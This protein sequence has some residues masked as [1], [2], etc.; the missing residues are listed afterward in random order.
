MVA[1]PAAPTDR[2]L[3][4]RPAGQPLLRRL[5]LGLLAAAL[6]AAVC[7]SGVAQQPWRA[8]KLTAGELG[9]GHRAPGAR[10]LP[11]TDKSDANGYAE[12]GDEAEGDDTDAELAASAPAPAPALLPAAAA[13]AAASEMHLIPEP[14]VSAQTSS[15]M[16]LQNRADL[17]AEAQHQA[18]AALRES[19]QALSVI[20]A[21]AAAL[22]TSLRATEAVRTPAELIL[23]P[24]AGP[25]GADAGGSG[26]GLNGESK[27]GTVTD[28]EAGEY[29]Q[30]KMWLKAAIKK[31]E[32]LKLTDRGLTK[33]KTMKAQLEGLEVAH[34]GLAGGGGGVEELPTQPKAGG[35]NMYTFSAVPVP[36]S[37]SA[38]P[39]PIYQPF[40]AGTL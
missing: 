1:A 27:V 3:L 31:G 20:E 10:L 33:L 29:Q 35:Q 19:E 30:T 13:A 26:V 37:P 28:E 36:S 39:I 9:A 4:A 38:G 16:E 11:E 21:K 5:A 23:G 12:E 8:Q 40:K 14:A 6:V 2:F 32:A 7:L 17:A 34:A 22:Q 18:E 24:L 15:L 25:L